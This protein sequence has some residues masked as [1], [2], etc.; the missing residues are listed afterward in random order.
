MSVLQ[1]EHPVLEQ[2]RV[3]FE[4]RGRDG[5]EGT[6]MLAGPSGLVTLCVIPEQIGR[7]TEFGVSVEVT[8]A[9][10]LQLATALA[11]GE[12]YHARIHSHPRAAFHSPLDDE[13]PGLTAQGSYSIVVEDFG[14]GLRRGLDGCAIYR[15]VGSVWVELSQADIERELEA[16]A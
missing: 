5:Y 4:E 11:P 15:L 2:A 9:G 12:I 7:R 1:I 13:N 10:K 8:M 3:F 16:V 14:R 6:A